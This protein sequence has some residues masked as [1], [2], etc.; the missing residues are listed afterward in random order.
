MTTCFNYDSCVVGYFINTGTTAEYFSYVDCYDNVVSCV[1]QTGETI[2][3]N[4]CSAN[5]FSGNTG[6]GITLVTEDFA[7][8]I[9]Y[10]SGCCNSGQTFFTL[11]N[12]AIITSGMS[13]YAEQ[14]IPSNNEDSVYDGCF[15][16]YSAVTTFPIPVQTEP[17]YTLINA[18][19][20][21]SSGCTECLSGTPCNFDCYR[22]I[23]C[24]GSIPSFTS[25]DPSL[26]GYVDNFI[27]IEITST[28][29][30]QIP[31]TSFV[32]K[33]I[34]SGTCDN[35]VIFNVLSTG[36]TCDCYCY[37]FKTPKQ[38][39]LTR[40]VD[41]DLNLM[42]VYFTTASTI[43][44]CSVTKPEFE[45]EFVLPVKVEGLC[46][47]G[48]CPTNVITI[49]PRNECDVLTIFPLKL[50]C[51]V[52]QPSE[53]GIFDGAVTLSISGGTPPYDI[54]WDFGG[55]SLAA[56]NLGPGVYTALVTDFYKDFSATTTCV[57]TGVT[58]STTTTTTT[59]HPITYPNL[60]AVLTV[61]GKI[62][63][64]AFEYVQIDLTPNGSLNG[65]E[66]WTSATPSYSLF[67]NTGNTSQWILSG[68]PAPNLSIVN[69]NPLIPPLTGWQVFGNPVVLNATVLSGSCSSQTLLDF[70]IT[71]S[72]VTC[73]N[74]GSIVIQAYGGTPPYQY[75]IDNGVTFYP[76]PIFQNLTAGSYIIHVKDAN[77]VLD[78]QTTQLTQSSLTNYVLSLSLSS[79]TNTFAISCPQL[80]PGQ[81]ITFA[82]Q[83]I[84]YLTYYPLSISG[85]VS[86]N[87][88]CT[89]SGSPMTLTNTFNNTT[90]AFL[91][92]CNP[93]NVTTA[94]Q[95][96]S[97][98]NQYTLFYG[99]TIT[100]SLTDV[101][102]APSGD[103]V[104]AQKNY[105]LLILAGSA[106]INN[107]TCC[108]ITI[109]NPKTPPIV[110][111]KV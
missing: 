51:E 31:D 48:E 111:T 60:C 32:V 62:P 45:Y 70:T 37:N 103:C 4:Y 69:N 33:Y 54:F 38:E 6:G 82:L 22:L 67:W 56:I 68:Y 57:L 78:I 11:A 30:S 52:I 105:Q 18:V 50:E 84:S 83:H 89:V 96:K 100:G 74:D 28:N 106:S 55:S 9:L 25:N 21:Y 23:S 7:D 77:N 66:S 41:C 110:I 101:L 44:L 81:S 42:E 64:N 95:Q 14:Y 99:Q 40:Y 46:V 39:I 5:D 27:N 71:K 91:P 29:P 63:G 85:S 73:E 17:Y 13:F 92:S 80:L 98:T 79:N 16:I 1:V 8:T 47:S 58:P 104:Q 86:Y 88:I 94:Q 26:S 107:C 20:T 36:D 10:L 24:D 90:N 2:Y 102:T 65:I 76:S 108:P 59:T 109:D 87:N 12:S 93:S 19:T 3:V 97:Y 15:E 72:N 43:S 61:R 34:G 75:S 53:V 35:E 49:A